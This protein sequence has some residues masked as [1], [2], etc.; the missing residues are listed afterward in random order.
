MA[1]IPTRASRFLAELKRRHV[2]RIAVAYG[3]IALAAGQ[4][5]SLLVEAL[6]LGPKTLSFIVVCLIVGFPV[7]LVLA[8][9]YDI[10][11]KG[12]TRTEAGGGPATTPRHSVPPPSVLRPIPRPSLPLELDS[13]LRAPE[14]PVA[15]PPTATSV[16]PDPER[17]RRASLAQLRDELRTPARAIVDYTR[18]LLD[19]GIAA[20]RTVIRADLEK[21]HSAGKRFLLGIEDLLDP[22]H[23]TWDREVAD[24]DALLARLRHDLRTPLN[25]IIG[26]SELVLED[27]I[28]PARDEAIAGDIR[29]I[30]SAARQVLSTVEEVVRFAASGS[31]EGV[32][33]TRT[34]ALAQEV[35]ARIQP[36]YDVSRFPLRQG[37]LLV[38]DDLDTNCDL[39]AHQL[40]R[41]GYTVS[42]AASGRE[43][44]ER[45]TSHDVDLVLLDILMPEIDGV[46][47]LRRVKADAALRDTPVIMISALDDVGSIMRCIELGA[48]DFLTK[49][50]D[51][52]LL[53]ARIDTILEVRRL[54]ER[55]Q[56]FADALRREQH[57]VGDLLERA[58]PPL[59]AEKLKAGETSVVESAAAATVLVAGFRGAG[60]VTHVGHVERLGELFSVFDGLASEHGIETIKTTGQSYIAIAGIPLPAKQ[61]HT[62]A[63]ADLALAMQ[64]AARHIA[65]DDRELRL[66]IG[67][68][69]GSVLAALITSRRLSF[70]VWGDGVDTAQQ[71]QLHA[72]PGSIQVSPATWSQLHDHYAFTSRGVVEIPGNGQ[73]RTYILQGR[74]EPARPRS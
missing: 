34:S 11:P 10:T 1:F 46:E 47:I 15:A 67:I 20:D 56:V 35:L 42:T 44:L 63:T 32:G 41:Q 28:D 18:A 19:E 61:N 48:E 39:I 40:A 16:P 43:A 8:W 9:A 64:E 33:L 29:R 5:A 30:L 71:L 27:E 55:E 66:R 65:E 60:V 53:G 69:I 22:S 37:K 21:V 68:H 38:V 17:V 12:V 74:L 23:P 31:A 24:R 45:L 73:M 6:E 26:Y 49:P 13:A 50:F 36:V 52:V 58:F 59:F 2:F 25:A 7:A 57:W 54:R 70:D 4:G 72:A 51:P 62:R 14:P 3:V